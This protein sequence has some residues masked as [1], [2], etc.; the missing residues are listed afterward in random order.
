MSQFNEV[1][2]KIPLPVTVVTVGRGGVENGLTVSWTCPVSF[3]PL[4]L[5]IGIDSK[6]YS[7]E[8]L[9]STKNFVINVLAKG[10]EKVAA[11]FARQSFNDGEKL[12]G[13]ATKESQTGGAI[14]T[15][16]VCYYDC[17][18]IAK[19]TQGDHYVYVGKVVAAEILNDV[20]P[21]STQ[22]GMRYT[23]K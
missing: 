23:K 8:F 11:R 20:E 2:K 10:Q 16:A 13:I 14:L 12:E 7:V 9:D 17:E 4:Q 22:N 15:D 5:M 19:H 1:L 21:M 3:D 6:H 18:V